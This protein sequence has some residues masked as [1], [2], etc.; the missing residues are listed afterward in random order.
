MFS[1]QSILKDDLS[2]R[3][4]LPDGKFENAV[5]D[6]GVLRDVLSEFWNDFYE[7][8]T[9]GNCFKVPY[10]RHDFGQQEWESVGRII[11]FGWQ[12]DQ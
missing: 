4:I 8:C 9:L 12:K 3:V 5:D 10:L 7:Q 11:T 6:G 2:F 1:E